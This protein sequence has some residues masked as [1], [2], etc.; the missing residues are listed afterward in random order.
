MAEITPWDVQGKVEYEKLIQQFG[1]QKVTPELL[2]H[3]S[4]YGKLPAL[5]RRGFFFSHRDYNLV[6]K[7]ADDK[8][9]FFLYTGRAPSGPMHLGHSIPFHITKWFQKTFDVNLYI[10]IPDEEKFLAKKSVKS[11]KDIDQYVEDNLLDIAAI[12][13]DPNKTF[14]FRNREYIKQLY[15][16]ACSVAKKI[17]FSTAKAVFGF[18]PETNIG[19][20]FYPALQ[21]V[22]TLFEQKRCLIPAAIDQDPYWRIQRDIAEGLGYKKAAVIHCKFLPPLTGME[23]KMS[24][25]NSDT[26][27][28][29]NDPPAMVEKKIMK[30]AFSGGQATLA[31][32]RAK[33]GN[34]DVDVAYQWLYA[35]FEEDDAKMLQIYK[36]YKSGKLLS[37]ELKKMLIEKVNAFLAEHQKN[38]EKN[39]KQ[40][41][42]MMYT[43]KLAKKMWSWKPETSK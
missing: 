11:L 43:G 39:K 17:T 21:I 8:V 16:P 36:D 27:I 28:W 23:G 30:Y 5:L 3:T 10:Q 4:R 14:I 26:A 13:F 15:E 19:W 6:L 25:S 22:P 24:S 37:G 7:D 38:R 31:E 1:T 9:G 34:P 33:G 12:G 2:D 18:T 42:Q 41:E 29:L 35:F 40:L 32:H 20:M